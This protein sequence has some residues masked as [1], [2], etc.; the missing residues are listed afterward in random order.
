MV[1]AGAPAGPLCLRVAALSVQ[2]SGAEGP[3]VVDP[4]G[5]RLH[6]ASEG[7]C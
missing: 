1:R 5:D 7:E 4:Q 6:R 3:A 2:R